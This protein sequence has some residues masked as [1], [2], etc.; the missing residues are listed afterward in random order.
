MILFG[1]S[2]SLLG[3]AFCFSVKGL[4]LH[5]IIYPKCHMLWVRIEGCSNLLDFDL[6]SSAMCFFLIGIPF[7]YMDKTW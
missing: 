3:L 1:G 2:S 6:S 4:S 7:Q 5:I